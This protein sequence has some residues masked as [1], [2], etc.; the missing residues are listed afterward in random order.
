[1]DLDLED[2]TVISEDPLGRSFKRLSECHAKLRSEFATLADATLEKFL[3]PELN[4]P[5]MRERVRKHGD[6]YTMHL[7]VPHA[8][9]LCDYNAVV[10]FA[11]TS[12]K[13]DRYSVFDGTPLHEIPY[14]RDKMR[15]CPVVQV[16]SKEYRL[17][18]LSWQ[19]NHA[20]HGKDDA[21]A[22]RNTKLLSNNES[23][24]RLLVQ[25][26]LLACEYLATLGDW[27]HATHRLLLLVHGKRSLDKLDKAL[28]QIV[29]SNK[30]KCVRSQLRGP[31]NYKIMGR[32]IPEH[33]REFAETT[34]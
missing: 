3:G 20:I 19:Q 26:P 24:R 5:E 13:L 25:E 14:W 15:L 29:G 32:L 34:G 23:I 21:D 11:M 7:R 33:L 31:K 16:D 28:R 17:L 2:M 8:V 4:C 12:P 18:F 30:A 27:C 10:L 1:M 22:K 9:R 6:G